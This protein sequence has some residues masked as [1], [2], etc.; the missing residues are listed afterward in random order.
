MLSPAPDQ[1]LARL[2]ALCLALPE[3][4]ELV[5]HGM[6]AFRVAAKMFAYFRHDHHGDG[7]TVVCVKTS[8]RDEQDHLIESDP[9]MFSWPAY[10]GPSGW[11][12]MNLAGDDV[13]WDRVAARIETSYRL[14]APPRLRGTP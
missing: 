11:I 7:R 6:P 2:R 1:T 14:A 12:A 10:I 5:S 8:G 4:T 3:T 13:D 9:D